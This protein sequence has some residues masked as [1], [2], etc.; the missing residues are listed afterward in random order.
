MRRFLLTLVAM[1]LVGCHH[2]SSST[3]VSGTSPDIILVTIDTLRADALGYA[4]NQVVKTPF[5]DHLAGEATVFTNAHAHNVVTLPSHVNILTG[6]YP[7]QHGVHDNAGFR[8]DAK[9]ETV[10]TMLHR[11][12][13]A[14]GAFIGAYPL[15]ARYGL[16]AGFDVYDD[17]YGKG[18]AS[19]DFTNQERPANTVLD[20]AV[21]WWNANA[22]KRRFL[23][24]HL[25][26]AHA[27]YRPPEPFATQYAA[28]PYLGEVAW[29]DHA[30]DAQLAPVI[31][32][33][34]KALVIITADHGEAL[35]DHGEL[36]HG[37]FAYEPTLKIPLLV[38]AAGVAHHTEP[39]Y[40]RHVDIVPTILEAAGVAKPALLPG[41]SLLGPIGSRDAYFESLSASLNR[42]WAPLTGVIHR[43]EKYIE[44]PIVELYD[45]PRDPREVTNL[46]ND[47]RRDAD[48]ARRLLTSM[49]EG[50]ATS[51]N[52]SPEEAARLRSLGY[53][54][55]GAASKTDYTAADDPKNLVA[56]DNKM[57]DV[58]DAY[59]RRD[60]GRALALAKEVVA[61][62]PEMAAGREL[63][64]FVLQQSENV[65]A[66]IENLR[67]A[68]RHGGQ[69]DATRVQLGLLLTESGKAGE[70]AEIL[71]P[72]AAGNDPDALNAF[73]I[74]LADQNRSDEAVRQFN[75]VLEADPNNAPALQNLGI[76]A[77]RRDDVAGAQT[78]LG[79]ALALNPRLPLALNTLGVVYARQGD[80][81]RAVS[82]WNQAVAIDPR[83]YDALFNAGL[84][85]GRAGH[86]NEAKAA[87]SRF[88][89]TA[90]KDR[91]RADINTARQALESLQ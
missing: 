53:V 31:A 84:V 25:Y 81:A 6:L 62:R 3:R 68:I 33:D 39:G 55:G 82:S 16:N 73:G 49:H 1:T 69:T 24:V 90:P 46:R 86:V 63:L 9:H 28:Q 35:G 12:G 13:Y 80:Y 78:Y 74:A 61:A 60:V 91:Y 19:L 32:A 2:E 88:V 14:T 36:T 40:V 56:L 42:G 54:S 17:N 66:A 22:G 18:A 65:P 27:P 44:L 71:A 41:A 7:Y 57:H 38:R 51:R 77:L 23:W 34:P 76:V 29:I 72:L 8:L 20:A 89:A 10:A 50:N 48:E 30:L 87:L 4:G 15:D 70:A 5:L 83:Q 21:H 37:L 64:A 67:E 47:R 45:L 43:G 11:A 59:E 26:D 75:R 79:R 58:I 85:E 52:V